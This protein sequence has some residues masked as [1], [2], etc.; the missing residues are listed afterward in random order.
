MRHRI[1]DERQTLSSRQRDLTQ[2]ESE[3]KGAHKSLLA[4]RDG[5]SSQ[6]AL[7]TQKLERLMTDRSELD[8]RR[9][10]MMHELQDGG[11]DNMPARLE[12]ALEELKFERRARKVE[13]EQ[14]A[15]MANQFSHVRE[16]LTGEQ[17]RFVKALNELANRD[18]AAFG[19]DGL[20]DSSEHFVLHAD[21]WDPA[22]DDEKLLFHQVADVESEI[23]S[24][25]EEQAGIKHQI[26]ETERRIG[27]LDNRPSTDIDKATTAA[28]AA[29]V[30]KLA[31][32]VEDL[33]EAA[34][35]SADDEEGRTKAFRSMLASVFGIGKKTKQSGRGKKQAADADT[36]DEDADFEFSVDAEDAQDDDVEVVTAAK[37]KPSRDDNP[38]AEAEAV[39]VEPHAI[40]EPDQLEP[41]WAKEVVPNGPAI[42]RASVRGESD[43]ADPEEH[44]R[45]KT[46]ELAKRM[47]ITSMREVANQSARNALAEHTQGKL[48]RKMW[49]D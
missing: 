6:L 29:K 2:R 25:N 17:A 23:E 44:R 34:R 7:M 41:E 32:S 21:D 27:E 18:L 8:V 13:R 15:A 14:L 37:R 24:L 22:S 1:H 33:A 35:E 30:E 3:V 20:D 16:Q 46:H 40:E 39:E 28:I 19:A 43:A 9:E 12:L 45:R 31:V 47:A 42:D 10:R 11:S 5:L 4:N 49:V 26:E 48:K 38:W 36:D